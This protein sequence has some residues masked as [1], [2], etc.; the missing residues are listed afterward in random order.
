MSFLTV[1][2]LA[3][4]LLNSKNATYFLVAARNASASSTSLKDVLADLIPKEQS[5]IKNF[6]QQYGKTNIGQITVDMVYGGMRGMKGLVYETSVLDPEEGIRFRGYSIPECQKLLPRAPGG[7]EPL[8]EGLFWLLVTGQVPTEEQV[9]WV[10]KEWA[11]RAALPS[12]VVTMLDNFP[13]NL[14]PMSQFSAAITALN[15]ESSFA[16]AYSEGVHKSKYWEFVYEDSMD[17]IA[18][19]PCI[20]AKIYRNLYREGSSIGAIDSNLD[21]SHN[22]TNMLGY[23]DTQFTELMRLYLTIHSDHEGGNVS[24]HTSH[25]VGSALSDPYLS[26]S[27]AMNGLAGPLHGLANQ[28]VLVWLTALQKELGGEVSD[29][30]MRDYIW[31]T[32][33][34]GRVV[35][36][37]GHAV[38][39]KTDPRYT[40]QREFALKHLPNDSMFKLVAQLYKIV[41]NVL[42]E[43][44]KAKNPWPNV[45][46]HSGVLLQPPL[47]QAIFNRN[48]EEVQLLLHKKED[49]NA[50]DQERRTPLHAAACVG[51]VHIMDLLIESGASVNAKDHVWLTPLHRAA[52]SRNERAVG[53]LLRR[54][55]EANA[56]DKFWQTP[57]HV[58]AANRATRCAEALL[59]QLSNLNMA[60]RTG[61]TALHHAA[62]SGFQE[63]VKLL[64]NKG[65]NL[66]AIDKKERQPIH[67]AAYLGHVEIVKLL[68][69]RSAD[70]SCKDKQGY[71]PLHAAAASGHIEIVKYL[72]RMGTEPNGFGNT[73]LHVACYMGQEA[74]ATELVN[75][76]ANVNQPNKCGYTPLHLAAVS[77]NGA[78]CLELL[79]NNGADV[80]QQSKEGKSPLHMAAIHG[81]FTR[82]QILIQNGGE[83]DCVDKYGNTPLHVA[84]KYGHELLISTLMTNGADTARRGIHGMFPL[85]LAVL[86]G[87]SDCCRK[88]LSSGQLYSIVSSMSKENVECLNLLLSSGTDLNK[89]DI[90][91]RTPLHYAAANGRY[92]CT[93]TLVSAGAEVNEPDQTGCTPLH[94]SAA[95]QAFS[96]CLEHL[97]DNGAD[98]SMVNSK[99]YSA[100]HYAAYHGN[101]QNLE[102]VSFL[103][104]LLEMSFNALGDIESSIPVSPL[105]LA[106]DKGHWQALRVLTETAAY[107]DMQDA[108]GRSVLYLAAQK[109]YARCVEVLLAQG[110]SCLL[111]DNRLMWTPIHVAA[112]HILTPLMLAILGGHTDCVHF[113]LEKGALPD[114]KDKRGSTALHR[115]AVLGHDDCVTAL[116]EHKASA[117]CRDTQGRTP[118]H[119]AASRGHTEILASLMQAA[120]ATDPQDKLLD[121]KQYTPLHWAAYKGHEDC[122]EVLLEFKTFIHEEGN[123]FTPLH[124][125]LMNGHSGAAERLLD[126]TVS[127]F[128]CRTPLHAAAF[129]EDVAGLQLVLRHGAEINAV[130]TSGC[131]ALMVAADK[132]HSG[133]VEDYAFLTVS[134][135]GPQAHEM[136]ALL[137]LGEIHSP[138]LIN[139]TNSALQMPL[140]LAARNGLATVVQ[141]L[142]SRGAT[143]LAVDEEGHTPAL[144]CAPNKDVADCLALILSTMKPF[145]QRDPSSC[146]CSSPT[147]SPS[148]GLN[149]LKHCGIT[150]TCAPLPSNGLHNGYVKDRH[151][152]PVGLDG[153]LSE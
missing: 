79:V 146:S 70:K 87:F 135:F 66:S 10:S 3:P 83:I 21:W 29:E 1:S 77:T 124:C 71:T 75:H 151:G 63:M 47:V 62:Q 15:S 111:N 123:P 113:L 108:A 45:D 41:P 31:N 68:V 96:S 144:A 18:K 36:G 84:A 140:H 67:C 13:T 127:V 134:L 99:G 60:D 80:N 19:L 121:N 6:K 2:R 54:G 95:S 133:T 64:L 40:C 116:L 153:C 128:A 51:D 61:R 69:S 82:S 22:F 105:H 30:R 58:A 16:R 27:A 136:C 55:A 35:P 56:R 104:N 59:S 5:R 130:D 141:A 42:L 37:Y 53:L 89:R 65:A 119:Y 85:H 4:K 97:L 57:L 76:G 149:L 143:V 122:L 8:P 93:V 52:A 14:H 74:V 25:L 86:Y 148:P 109:G 39:R 117:L 103:F 26:F 91:G 23:S 131:S 118:L 98:P 106:A 78:L 7:E 9:N 24:A 50:L 145:P 34:S 114:A 38:L 110:A 12:H 33:K 20:A 100:V 115:G 11:K 147:V 90:M 107:V 139:A 129:A 132:G 101:K 92:Q 150:A 102:L 88:L 125:A 94:Y 137:I 46:A 81:R 28:E 142:L 126:W 120:M 48:A 112:L 49:V 43:Q 152:A 72:L 44:G 32:L 73:A 138:T 17:L